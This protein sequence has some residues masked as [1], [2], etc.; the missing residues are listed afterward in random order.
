MAKPKVRLNYG[1]LNEMLA[2][3]VEKEANRIAALASELSASEYEVVTGANTRG[4]AK[5]RPHAGV[6]GPMSVEIETDALQR[7]LGAI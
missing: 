2:P 4:K 6:G 1:A 3:I 7:A 5:A